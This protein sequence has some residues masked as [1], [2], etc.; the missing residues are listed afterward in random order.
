MI[1]ANKRFPDMKAMTDY[2]HAKGLKA[3]IYT[4]PGPTTCAGYVGRLP[5]RGA[6]RPA[7]RRVGLRFPEV[8]LVLLRQHRQRDKSLA[9]LQKPYRLISG[10]L[11]RAAARHRLQPLPVRHGQRLGMGPRGRRQQLAHRRRSGGHRRRR[12]RSSATASTSIPRTSSTATAA[13]AAGT[14]PTTCCSASS[15]AIVATRRRQR[16]LARSR[17]TSSTPT[18]R[19][20]ALVAAPLIFSG[21][22][23]RLDDFTLEPAHQRRGH[24]R[25]PGPARQARPPRRQG[26][27]PRGLGPGP[28]GRLQGRRPLQ[29]RRGLAEVTA[30]WSDLGVTGP[31]KVRDLW[32]QKDLG[33]S[34][35]IVHGLRRPPRRRHDPPVAHG[36]IRSGKWG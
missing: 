13:R 1:N 20:G 27:R 14:I 26:R 32:R 18:S 7:L 25:R 36:Q 8:R 11:R 17:R 2:I 16:G 30:R 12:Q 31:Q 35:G 21:D 28:G 3:G 24:R 15:S 23:T 6:R 34:D 22:I 33:V 9:E 10:I 4:S 29:P 19:S 5:A